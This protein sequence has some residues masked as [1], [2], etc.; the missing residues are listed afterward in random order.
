MDDNNEQLDFI[1]EKVFDNMNILEKYNKLI[2][3]FDI[4]KEYIITDLIKYL[5]EDTYMN[6]I[7]PYTI[8]SQNEITMEQYNEYNY[9]DNFSNYF[10]INAIYWIME[11][12]D[13][14]TINNDVL[15]ELSKN[16]LFQDLSLV[17]LYASLGKIEESIIND[18]EYYKYLYFRIADDFDD[19]NDIDNIE[20][21]NYIDYLYQKFI[22]S[23]L[24]SNSISLL[25]PDKVDINIITSLAQFFIN[26]IY[27]DMKFY[28]KQQY[29]YIN[30]MLNLILIS[31]NIQSDTDIDEII[32][33]I[34]ELANI[35]NFSLRKLIFYLPL[36]LD[37]YDEY[38]LDL[39]DLNDILNLNSNTL[40]P[41]SVH[42]K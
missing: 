37:D 21:I 7:L 38:N 4:S 13:L 16:K 29:Y 23:N 35:N 3:R 20:D 5:N 42:G 41:I 25:I 28:K 10:L 24:L 34:K 22:S 12:V 15:I 32:Y 8:L 31:N 14:L 27:D 17:I 18:N 30:I 19:I 6:D 26:N 40:N 1:L 2:E 33:K 39:D 11:S 9:D 36:T